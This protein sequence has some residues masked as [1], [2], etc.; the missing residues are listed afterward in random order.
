[1]SGESVMPELTIADLET[2]FTTTSEN[3]QT[4]FDRKLEIA[5]AAGQEEADAAGHTGE[6]GIETCAETCVLSIVET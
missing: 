2:D 5:E 1:M 4:K 6:E 3:E